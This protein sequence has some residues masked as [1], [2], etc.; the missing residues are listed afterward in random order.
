M[1]PFK[2]SSKRNKKFLYY[3][4][5][6]YFAKGLTLLVSIF[7]IPLTYN[8]LG[9]TEFGILTTI[10]ST[11]SLISFVDLGVGQ[12]LQNILPT[13]ATID[14][15]TNI[16]KYIT[17]AHLI[18]ILFGLT[19]FVLSLFIIYI[20]NVKN[21]LNIGYAANIDDSLLVFSVFF[22]LGIPLSIVQRVQSALQEGY[23]SQIWSGLS[24][25]VSLYFLNMVVGLKLPLPWILGA[26]YGV[27]LVFYI[28][29][30]LH[31]FYIRNPDFR[32]RFVL[33][34]FYIIKKLLN[35]GLLF[36]ILQIFSLFLTSSTNLIITNVMGI[37]NVS[38][39]SI[40]MRFVTLISGPVTMVFPAILPSVNDALVNGDNNWIKRMVRKAL[41][42]VLLYST[43]TALI[44]YFL[45]QTILNLWIGDSFAMP[46]NLLIPIISY[47]TFLQISSLFSFVMLSSYY[48]KKTIL[49]YP[50]SVVFSIA[51]KYF[52]V[53]HIGV[54]GVIWG[55]V[56]ALSFLFLIPS[57]NF[58]KK[59]NHI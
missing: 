23:I 13:F 40:V 57:I 36:V 25:I 5:S 29:N 7:S 24:S 34:D 39:F 1:F 43:V 56:I 15:K 26:L 46:S 51:F 18:Q 14:D 16:K 59:N 3:A 19:A 12:G 35:M 54:S 50:L 38:D 47:S 10:V 58:L 11:M 31:E 33:G 20:I 9:V 2:I 27:P 44:I 45:S 8:Y 6:T 53:V 37:E 30:Y 28:L 41:C 55:E 4:L 21:V 48:L 49:L 42:A 17:N 52:L 32:P 22:C